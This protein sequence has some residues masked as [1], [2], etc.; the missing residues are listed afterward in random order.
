MHEQGPNENERQGDP[1]NPEEKRKMQ[2]RI[3]VASLADYNEG[4]LHGTW[5][6]AAQSEEELGAAAQEMLASSPAPGAE[7]W[8]IHDYE[9]FGPLHLDEFESLEAVAKVAAGIVERGPAFAAWAALVGADSERL[10]EFDDSYMG[11]YESGKAF[12][13]EMLDDMGVLEPLMSQLPEHLEGY[14]KIDH[15]SYFNDLVSGGTITTMEKPDG[16]IYVFWNE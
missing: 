3:Y 14:V 15:E 16:A 1:A 11:E 6:D 5:I 8:A 13:E 7:E 12:A 4:R 9:G 2:P 10:G